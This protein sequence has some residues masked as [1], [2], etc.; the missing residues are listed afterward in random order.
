MAENYNYKEANY[1]IYF[2][3]KNENNDNLQAIGNYYLIKS[4]ESG[5]KSS[6]NQIIERLGKNIPSEDFLKESVS[7]E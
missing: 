6:K 4:Y 1:A 5:M 7:K 3:L 2:I